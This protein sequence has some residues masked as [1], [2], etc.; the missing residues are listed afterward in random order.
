MIQK[1]FE[2]DSNSDYELR[3]DI[4]GG[5]E[6]EVFLSFL[7]AVE[8]KKDRANNW[9]CRKLKGSWEDL[10]PGCADDEGMLE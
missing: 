9:R 4:C 5:D 2:G 1:I 8:F 6:G 10:C 3:C 7:E